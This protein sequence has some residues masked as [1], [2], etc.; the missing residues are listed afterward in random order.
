MKLVKQSFEILEQTDFS[1]KGIKQFIERCGRVCYKSEDKITDTSYEKF[2]DMLERKDH[3]RPLEFGTVHL[4]MPWSNFNNFVGFCIS[5]AVWDNCWIKY[6]VDRDSE[7][8]TVY[9]TTNY[10]YYKRLKSLRPLY[11]YI[12]IAEF[13]TEEDNEYYPKRYTVHFITSRGI[14][15]EFRTHVGLSHLAESTRYVSS[16]QKRSIKEFNC[17]NIEDICTAYQQGFSMREIAIYSSMSENTI[18]RRLIDNSIPIRGLNNKG[19][20][21]E[22]YFSIIDT[23]EKAYLLGIIQTDGNV[24]VSDRNASLTITQHKDYAWYIKDMLLNLSDYVGD[25]ED[26]NCRQLQIGSKQIV[27]D[28]I[29]IGIIPNKTYIQSDKDVDT[30]WNSVPEEYKGDFIRGLIDGDGNVSFFT[31]KKGINESCNI[32]FVSVKEHLIDILIDY[33]YKKFNYKCGK[34][35]EGNIYKLSITDY[36]KSLEIGKFLYINFQ[37]PFGHPK[38]ASAWIKRLNIDYPI[39]NY[40]DDKFICIKPCWL[41]ESSPL[42]IFMY[43]HALDS[44]ED[45]YTNLRLGGWTPQQAR[46][47]LPLSVKSELISCGFESAWSNF[48]YRRC[49]KDAHPMA[50]EIAIPLQDK[51]KEMRLSF[52]Y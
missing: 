6:H 30:L 7:D 51:F 4:K 5:K 22:D 20:R 41:K 11:G 18:K 52:V 50:R 28:L 31:Q 49:A 34:H 23:P 16:C 36:N 42:S 48:F 2:V 3:A 1:L 45:V 38:K 29:N 10:R 33:I 27:N 37:Y 13:F 21:V 8:K 47:V 12:N 14:M 32:G 19:N 26:R 9:I 17:D 15:D 35:K 46:E 40:K 24:R 44:S 25:T 43:I 39:A